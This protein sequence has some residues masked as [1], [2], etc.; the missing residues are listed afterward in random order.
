[1]NNNFEENKDNNKI[2]LDKDKINPN[3]EKYI[4]TYIKETKQEQDIKNKKNMKYAFIYLFIII[5]LAGVSFLIAP[6]S[7]LK[8]VT[9]IK[10]NI[11]ERDIFIY[12][13]GLV[14]WNKKYLK[15]SAPGA[16]NIENTYRYELREMLFA[17][18]L[19]GEENCRSITEAYIKA[20]KKIKIEVKSNS[21]TNVDV[22]IYMFT[23]ED[24]KSKKVNLHIHTIFSDGMAKPEDI[25]K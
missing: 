24:F 25:I 19:F 15:K 10:K 14:N 12:T 2:N 18:E 7:F 17:Q 11:Q 22:N 9:N 21:E 20:R 13:S 23:K 1:M 4:D 8:P 6:K 16:L 5:I 3:Y